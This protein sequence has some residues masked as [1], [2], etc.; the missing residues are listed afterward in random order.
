MW[1]KNI[2]GGD[3]MTYWSVIVV[4]EHDKEHGIKGESSLKK[5]V[6]SVWDT[7]DLRR[8]WSHSTEAQDQCLG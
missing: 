6:S 5:M 8:R 3:K 2:E 7:A 4:E 1:S